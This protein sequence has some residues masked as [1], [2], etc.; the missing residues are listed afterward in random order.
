MNLGFGRFCR[1]EAHFG[2]CLSCFIHAIRTISHEL[3][4][5]YFFYFMHPYSTPDRW[6]SKTLLT[7][8]ERIK[9]R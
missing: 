2:L 5:F 1:D 4:C 6:Q 9:Y 7:I 8:D 3:A